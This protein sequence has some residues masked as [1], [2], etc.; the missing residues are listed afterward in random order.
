MRY[1][2]TGDGHTYR[3]DF[4]TVS[5]PDNHRFHLHSA[6]PLEERLHNQVPIIVRFKG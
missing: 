2:S 5:V 1:K 4:R 6:G 3:I